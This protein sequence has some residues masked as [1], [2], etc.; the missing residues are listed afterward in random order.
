MKIEKILFPTQFRELAFNTLESLFVLKEAG[1]REILLVHIIPRDEVAFVPFGGYLKEEEEHLRQEARIRFEAW[2]KALE[3]EGIG[4]RV[5]IEVGD[6]VPRILSIADEEGVDLIVTGKKR[7]TGMEELFIG[8]R[9]MDILRRTRRPVLVHKY[10]VQFEWNGEIVTRTNDRIFERPLLATDWSPAS[11]RALEFLLTLGSIVK[12]VMVTH[13]I[14]DKI[15]K[16][17]EQ[18]ELSRIEQ[19]SRERL[20]QYCRALRE[21]GVDA[22]PHLSAGNEVQ[23]IIQISREFNASMITG[24][25]TGKDRLHG[26]IL[27]SVSHRIAETSEL[28]TLLVP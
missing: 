2:Q 15:A 4:S 14:G 13:I 17:L 27:G 10:M 1:L 25:T 7:Q 20:E 11:G 18:P 3:R 19:E 24:G 26:L 21:A 23:E 16:G 6:P 22:D 12:K 5:V 8:S 9:T 28:P